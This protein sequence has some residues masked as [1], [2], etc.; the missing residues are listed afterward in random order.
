MTKPDA[1]EPDSSTPESAGWGCAGSVTRRPPGLT[2]L[3]V[4][5]VVGAAPALFSTLTHLDK[6]RI[7]LR[8]PQTGAMLYEFRWASGYADGNSVRIQGILAF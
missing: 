5:D 4:I 1:L 6:S 3:T 2:R 8:H 7:V